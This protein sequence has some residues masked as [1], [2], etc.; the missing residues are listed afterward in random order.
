MVDWSKTLKNWKIAKMENCLVFTRFFRWIT[1]QMHEKLS[2]VFLELHSTEGQLRATRMKF[3]MGD[4][5]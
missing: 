5:K 4:R 3:Y 1:C 2:A